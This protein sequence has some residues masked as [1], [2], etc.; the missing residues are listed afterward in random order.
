MNANNQNKIRNNTQNLSLR[1]HSATPGEEETTI[2]YSH[3]VG[4][5]FL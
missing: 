2:H 5:K 1:V 3:A 4:G